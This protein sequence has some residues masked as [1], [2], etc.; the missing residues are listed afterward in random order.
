MSRLKNVA[1]AFAPDAGQAFVHPS[2]ITVIA[3]S[4]GLQSP[5]VQESLRNA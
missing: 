1:K 4:V 5:G 3:V 2:Q